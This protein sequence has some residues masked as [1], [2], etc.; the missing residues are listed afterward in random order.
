MHKHREHENFTRAYNTGQ[1]KM[2]ADRWNW[3]YFHALG[4]HVRIEP[5]G[6]GRM[7]GMDVSSTKLFRYQQKMGRSAPAAGAV[8]D[9]W[10]EK[11]YRY[12]AREDHYRMKAARKGRIVFLPFKVASSPPLQM[13]TTGTGGQIQGTT[14]TAGGSSQEYAQRAD[15]E[16][17]HRSSTATQ[18]LA[19][20]DQAHSRSKGL[21]DG[22]VEDGAKRAPFRGDRT[23]ARTTLWG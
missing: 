6:V 17:L 22:S 19:A 1:L 3:Q 14:A 10:D 2:L 16:E 20:S 21:Y 23:R 13:G 12:Q 9:Q 15:A 18:R 4:L 11:E 7:D 8:A 5:P